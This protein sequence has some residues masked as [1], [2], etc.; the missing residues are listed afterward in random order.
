[1]TT[2]QVSPAPHTAFDI[3]PLLFAHTACTIAMMA[4]VSLIGPIARVLDLAPWQAGAAMTV[5][6]V[7]W[8]LLALSLIHI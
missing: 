6:G 2:A 3:R 7:I 1:M 5:S 4:F 8:M